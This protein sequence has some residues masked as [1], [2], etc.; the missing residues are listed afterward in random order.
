MLAAVE[1][2]LLEWESCWCRRKGE[3]AVIANSLGKDKINTLVERLALLKHIDSLS[4]K[5][6]EGSR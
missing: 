4:F 2:D 6:R 1:I 5:R 3:T